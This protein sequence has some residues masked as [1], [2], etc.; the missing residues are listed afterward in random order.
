VAEELFFRGMIY[1]V[2]RRRWSAG[3]AIVL[4]AGVF[5]LVHFIPLLMPSLFYVGLLLA[6]VR[7]RSNSVIPGILMHM[8][9]NTIVTFGIYAVSQSQL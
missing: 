2:M 3:W 5:A 6:W 4:N 9:Q 7:E 8:L 1:P